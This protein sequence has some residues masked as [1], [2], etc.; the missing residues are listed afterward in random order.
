M[1]SAYSRTLT[2]QTCLRLLLFA[3]ILLAPQLS[4]FTNR[5]MAQA[6]DWSK[7]PH[8]NPMHSRLPCLLCH[9]RENTATQPAMPGGNQHTPCTGCH[10]KQFA[11]SSNP[12]CT[13]CHS[14]VKSG[15][16]K[17]FPRLKS[18]R[19]NFDHASHI[20]MG[21]V[22]CGTCHRPARGGMALSIPTGFS[23]HAVCN[24]CHSAQAQSDG[25]DISSCGTCHSLGSYSRTPVTAAAFRMGFSHARHDEG[26]ACKTC[27]SIRPGQPQRSQVSAPQAA[28]HHASGRGMSCATCHN[29][30]RAFGGDDFSSCKRCHAGTTWRF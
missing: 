28:N 25:R 22:S 3:V 1:R 20:A 24:R 29:G 18:F 30:T 17:A 8:S 19:V 12:V 13:I 27:H 26:L 15:A 2:G 7:F 4:G 5:L 6:G 14:D 11:D 9:R 16:V 21:S 10:A 23:A